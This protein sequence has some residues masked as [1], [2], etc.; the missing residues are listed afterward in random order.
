MTT[1]AT[2]SAFTELV[3]VLARGYLRSTQT[4]QNLGTSRPKEPQKELDVSRPESPAVL[5]QIRS[6]RR[7]WTEP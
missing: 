1:I 2:H 3:A 6:G 4:A 5:E 7:Q